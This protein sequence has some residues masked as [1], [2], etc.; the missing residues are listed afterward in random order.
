MAQLSYDSMRNL[1]LDDIPFLR[2]V[3][4]FTPELL[5]AIFWEE[6]GFQNIPQMGGG[7]AVGFGQVERA[8]IKMVNKAFNM[9]F[10]PEKIL[11]DDG[12]SVQ[13]ASYT[14]SLLLR[15]TR[16]KLAALNGYAGASANP[17]NAPIP[18]RWLEC[19]KQLLAVHA[20]DRSADGTSAFERL[21]YVLSAAAIKKALKA[22][23]PSSNP[24]V[25]F[26]SSRGIA[27]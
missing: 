6:S 2:D 17:A 12:L 24:D 20:S 1:I 25:A 7:P 8:T 14:L 4:V 5:T 3:T 13:I 10:T 19:E 18:G 15:S 26:P 27:I 16:N 9:N 22:A 23:K 21:T 11:A